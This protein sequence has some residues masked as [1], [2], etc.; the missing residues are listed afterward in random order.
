M[1]RSQSSK[2][3]Q[4]LSPSRDP[5]KRENSTRGGKNRLRPWSEFRIALLQYNFEIEDRERLLTPQDNRSKTNIW[6]V[7]DA[8]TRVRHLHKVAD[9]R[10]ALPLP[11][12]MYAPTT[13]SRPCAARAPS[14]QPNLASTDARTDLSR[15]Q[16]P[17]A[18][19]YTEQD[20]GAGDDVQG[21]LNSVATV[22]RK[23]YLAA[24]N[25]GNRCL[26]RATLYK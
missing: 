24:V 1:L 19:T 26:A 3:R 4:L 21:Q 9:T 7:L 15:F 2:A 12:V 16:P 10:A 20:E 8:A 5:R 14:H 13:R 18:S 22:A 17:D 23:I 25:G 6:Y 11:G